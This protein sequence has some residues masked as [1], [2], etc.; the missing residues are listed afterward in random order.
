MLVVVVVVV[1]VAVVV[2]GVLLGE[3][4]GAS[5]KIK[6]YKNFDFPAGQKKG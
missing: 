2:V 3:D 6:K 4:G 5:G 1:V